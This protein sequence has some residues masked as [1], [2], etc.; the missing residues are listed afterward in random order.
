MKFCL[1]K[2]QLLQISIPGGYESDM[3]IDMP[4][5]IITVDGEHREA[6]TIHMKIANIRNRS[7][8]D[9]EKE[10]NQYLNEL[11]SSSVE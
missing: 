3:E 1:N 6:I 8:D 11:Y 5:A 9:I 10:V 2:I 4:N 7:L